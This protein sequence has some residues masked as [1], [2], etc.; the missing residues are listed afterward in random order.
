[1]EKDKKCPYCNTDMLSG[2]IQ[3]RDG[4]YWC[5]NKRKIAALPPFKDNIALANQAG[6]FNGH[7]VEA[8]NCPK[9][10]KIIIYYED[11]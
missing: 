7:S 4:V 2:Y 5:K 6:V 8:Y 11:A 3:C 9:C 10:K 1:M